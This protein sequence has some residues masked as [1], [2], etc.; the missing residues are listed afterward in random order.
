MSVRTAALGATSYTSDKLITTVSKYI[1]TITFSMAICIL[2]TIIWI[3][4]YHLSPYS[5]PVIHG[6]FGIG[7]TVVTRLLN[8]IGIVGTVVFLVLPEYRQEL[9]AMLC[10]RC[11]KN[12]VGAT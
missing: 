1:I 2:P 6:F 8:A 5:E 7:N 4:L 9:R 10:F 11:F 3:I 12:H